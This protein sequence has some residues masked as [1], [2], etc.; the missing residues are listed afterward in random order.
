MQAY[1]LLESRG[2]SMW[3]NSL[4][5][6]QRNAVMLTL[7]LLT[8]LGLGR[9]RANCNTLKPDSVLH[10]GTTQATQGPAH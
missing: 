5:L 1:L 2:Q 8:V 3:E 7:V 6:L 10:T 4:H 9:Q